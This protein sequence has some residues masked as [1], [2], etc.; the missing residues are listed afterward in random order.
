MQVTPEVYD[1][2]TCLLCN[3]VRGRQANMMA[4]RSFLLETVTLI[5]RQLPVV[6]VDAA[7]KNLIS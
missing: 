6:E 2:L 7:A 3:L 4:L 1:R 5:D